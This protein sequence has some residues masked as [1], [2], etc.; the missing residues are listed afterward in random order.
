MVTI[1]IPMW[2]QN[3]KGETLSQKYLLGLT[4]YLRKCSFMSKF[5]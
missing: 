5:R 3:N 4:K 1:N 2:V